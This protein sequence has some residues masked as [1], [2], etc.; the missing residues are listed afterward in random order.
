M[1]ISKARTLKF[2]S[3]FISAILMCG[4]LVLIG[5]L[6]NR[7]LKESKLTERYVVKNEIV[8]YLNVAAGWQAIERGYG[9]TIIGSGKGSS[10]PLFP[11]FLKMA[12]NGDFE[13]SK[14]RTAMKKLLSVNEDKV[15]ETRII[16]YFGSL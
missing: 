6:I 15:F 13:V 14:A 1:N 7:S 5:I 12:E 11:K 2:Q 10:S 16:Q 4:L 8:G 9:A 3:I